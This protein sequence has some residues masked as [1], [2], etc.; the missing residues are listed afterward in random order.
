MTLC[1]SCP[2]KRGCKYQNEEMAAC[3]IRNKY[4]SDKK[5]IKEGFITFDSNQK[6]ITHFLNK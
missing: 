5:K 3:L 1:A 2:I 6:S 4:E